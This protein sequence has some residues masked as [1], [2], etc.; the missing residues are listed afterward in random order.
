MLLHGPTYPLVPVISA[1]YY[2]ASGSA[3]FPFPSV[4]G[5]LSCYAASGAISFPFPSIS[6]EVVMLN[7]IAF[8][9]ALIAPFPTMSGRGLFPANSE[10]WLFDYTGV[11]WK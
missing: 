11:N 6:G 8:D 5:E 1:Q 10:V 2:I 7:N 9:G 3:S 4:N